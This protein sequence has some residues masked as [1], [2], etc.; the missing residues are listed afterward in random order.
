MTWTTTRPTAPGWYFLR[1]GCAPP[2]VRQV[3]DTPDGLAVDDGRGN[4]WPLSTNYREYV[5]AGPIPE[6]TGPTP[7]LDAQEGE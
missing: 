2:R 7:D 1:L 4:L 3:F 5:W 6:P